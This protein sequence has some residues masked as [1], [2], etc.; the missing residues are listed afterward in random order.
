MSFWSSTTIKERF[1]TELIITQDNG[2][3]WIDAFDEKRVQHG[4]Y[5][6]SLGSEVFMTS[7]LHGRKTVLSEKE[8]VVIPPGQFAILLTEERLSLPPSCLGF[9]S[10]KA[11][12][13]FCGLVNVS[14]F[15]VDPGYQARLKFSVYNAGSRDVILTR[16]KALFVLWIANFDAPITDPYDSTRST[17]ELTDDD[18]MKIQGEI[19]SPAELLKRVR[20]IEE[21]MTMVKTMF[22]TILIALVVTIVGGLVVNGLWDKF[23]PK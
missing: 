22:T 17:N 7:E 20:H 14:G 19:A 5:E 16:G 4:S 3:G 9:I 12:K 18:I 6:L 2:A 15:H 1:S 8:Q 23:H 11:S 21:F 10:I 13:K